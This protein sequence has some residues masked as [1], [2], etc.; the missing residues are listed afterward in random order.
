[1]LKVRLLDN[2]PSEWLAHRFYVLGQFDMCLNIVDQILHKNPENPEALS[3]KGSVLRAKGQIDEAMNCFQ[4]AYDL[5]SENIRH[6]VEIAKCL[7]FLGRYEQSLKTLKDIENSDHGNSWEV[8]HLFGQNYAK[9][10]HIDKAIEYYEYAL[11]ADRRLE[12]ILELLSIYESKPDN[13]ALNA[14]LSEADPLHGKNPQFR[15]RVG[16]INLKRHSHDD[17]LAHFK[18]ACSKDHRDAKSCLFAGAIEQENQRQDKAM[19]MYRQAFQG[20][21]TSPALWNNVGL[22]LQLRSRKEAVIACCQKATF[23]APFEAIPLVNMGLVFLEM[24]MYCSAAIVLKRALALDPQS[25]I[26]GEGLGVALMNLGEYAESIRIFQSEIKKQR[27]HSLQINLALCCYRA[28]RKPECFEAF[29][30][31]T[32]LLKEE[33]SLEANYPEKEILFSIF[34]VRRLASEIG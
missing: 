13:H 22:G 30:H 5:D 4:T 6:H 18:Y 34:P 7:F 19:E 29:A 27:T 9:L 24:E 14:L 3:L 8:C 31:F 2:R 20:L 1:M 12:T 21:A 17:A 25:Q 28:E 26:A 32:R 16:K 15:R 11:D 33:P 10:R 23:F